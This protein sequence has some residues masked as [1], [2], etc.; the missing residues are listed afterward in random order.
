MARKTIPSSASPD[1]APG[2]TGGVFISN[3][4]RL[5]P[6]GLLMPLPIALPAFRSTLYAL[7]FTS[8]GPRTL[9]LWTF[10]T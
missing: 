10:C 8:F 1:S 5:R 7:R 4:P 9:T 2:F 3:A 6:G